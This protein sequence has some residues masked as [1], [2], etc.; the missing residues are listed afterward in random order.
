[1]NVY[2]YFYPIF[3]NTKIKY[4][5]HKFCHTLFFLINGLTVSSRRELEL[6]TTEL[7]HFPTFAKLLR[8][9]DKRSCLHKM[10]Q[11]SLDHERAVPDMLAQ[12]TK[13]L[14]RGAE[15]YNMVDT[16]QEYLGLLSG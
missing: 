16:K 6:L 10:L 5:F 3:A 13:G 9:G 8:I 15:V 4:C 7:C 1:M 11:A 2:P 12:V 14:Y